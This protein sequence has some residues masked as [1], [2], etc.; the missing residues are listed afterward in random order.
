MK[1]KSFTYP[2]R[3]KLKS[4]KQIKRVFE[5]GSSIKSYPLL[6]RYVRIEEEDNKVGVSVS[7][8]NFRKA[9]DRIRI[10]RQLREAY[11][12]HKHE[13]DDSSTTF[14]VMLIFIGKTQETSARIH[15]KVKS[16]LKQMK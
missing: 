16:L 15:E 2:E 13:I 12:L 14:A 7:K 5:E 6:I 10:K 4:K 8:R 9:V 11:R 1:L 3:E